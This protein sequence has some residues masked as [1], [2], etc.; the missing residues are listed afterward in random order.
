VLALSVEI[1]A[2]YTISKF[3]Q[4]C[5]KTVQTSKYLNGSCP[6]CREGKSWGRKRRLY[7]MFQ[8]DY[9]YCQNCSG[10][11]TPYFWIKEVTGMSWSDIKKEVE[12][13]TGDQII[14]TDFSQPSAEYSPDIP[15]L[16]GECVNIGDP[17]QLRYYIEN[18]VINKAIDY[19]RK[20]R[21]DTALFSPKTYYVC[22]ND[23][24]NKNRL[25]IPYF[26]EYGRIETYIGRTFLP[27]D[28][29]RKYQLK[30]NSPKGVFNLNKIDIDFP[31]IFPIEGPIDTMF[32][33]NGVGISGTS[34]TTNQEERINAVHPEHK[35][36]W[37][38]DNQRTEGEEVRNKIVD[39][40]KEGETVFMWEEE[41]E[42]YKD[43][44]VYCVEKK[45]DQVD[46][47]LIEKYSYSGERAL[48]RL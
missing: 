5:G 9:L 48:L 1:P 44:N 26:D 11:W 31:Y 16:P 36:I 40:I 32:L 17:N 8:G 45:L 42:N 30:F 22:L 46:P 21:L 6:I 41:F 19:I 7:Y 43:L 25:I 35:K 13:Y 23:K 18:P 34:M 28:E 39:K 37:V 47:A 4:Y 14:F 2:S 38:F 10:S 24:Y 12:E 27:N 20:R 3:R 15:V 29:R 33:R